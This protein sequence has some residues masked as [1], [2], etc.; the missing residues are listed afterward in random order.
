MEQGRRTQVTLTLGA[1]LGQ[2]V[3]TMRLVAFEAP[4]SL[5]EPFGSATVGLYLWHF[6]LLFQAVYD[7]QGKCLFG[8]AVWLK[9][10]PCK[11]NSHSR[12]VSNTRMY[13]H[14]QRLVATENAGIRKSHFLIP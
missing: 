13:R 5:F 8:P 9:L 10:F 6:F 3:T 1:L 12:A 14:F 2:D 7:D 11:R 4:S